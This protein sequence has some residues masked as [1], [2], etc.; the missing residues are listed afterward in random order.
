MI[1]KRDSFGLLS[2]VPRLPTPPRTALPSNVNPPLSSAYHT[3][4]GVPQTNILP[5]PPT[6]TPPASPDHS[7]MS[8]EAKQMLAMGQAMGLID[9]FGRPN[10]ANLAKLSPQERQMLEMAKKSGMLAG[11]GFGPGPSAAAPPQVTPPNVG[12]TY[13]IPGHTTLQQ[14]AEIQ[15]AQ[16]QDEA[17]RLAAQ[18]HEQAQIYAMQQ[19]QIID[20]ERERLAT[21][22]E[23]LRLQRET[24]ER[25]REILLRKAAGHGPG[26]EDMEK[27]VGKYFNVNETTR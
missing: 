11:L 18:Q 15:A 4:S 3:A 1:I 17:Q 23:L 21:E 5:G 16:Q 19:Q 25:E 13:G 8:P 12:A 14:Q 2:Q 24:F 7:K 26:T 27:M 20:Q 22:A 9:E 6:I 10:L